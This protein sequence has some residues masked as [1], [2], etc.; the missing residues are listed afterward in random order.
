L[1]DRMYKIR[2]HG[3]TK[4]YQ[5]EVLGGNFRMEELQG[6]VLIEKLKYLD[7]WNKKRREV[8]KEYK[9]HLKFLEEKSYL[10]L[11]KEAPYNKHIFHLFVVQAERRDELL[12]FLNGNFIE[13]KIHY[14]RLLTD[15]TTFK[16]NR[17]YKNKEFENAKRI[18]EKLLSLPINESIKVEDI[19]YITKVLEQFYEKND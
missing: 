18:K 15:L 8:A 10:V 4:K 5:H 13:A 2:N 7:T 17:Y 16:E 11:P 14:P 1:A 9:K 6:A 3:G 19:T 12:K